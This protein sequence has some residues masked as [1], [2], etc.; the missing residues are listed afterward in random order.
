M[1]IIVETNPINKVSMNDFDTAVSNFLKLKG[2]NDDYGIADV[3]ELS[4]GV[5]K[6]FTVVSKL[7]IGYDMKS[8]TEGKN[9]YRTSC[10]LNWM[11]QENLIPAG[12]YQVNVSW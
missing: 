5:I 2:L 9:S 12:K 3:E 11:C 10:I 1:K 7:P 8:L 6:D 4:N